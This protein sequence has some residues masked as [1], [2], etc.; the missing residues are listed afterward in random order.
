MLPTLPPTYKIKSDRG[1]VLEGS[2]YE[3]ELQLNKV[4][5]FLIEKI[6]GW[7]NIKKKKHGLVKWVGYDDSYNSWEPEKEIKDLKDLQ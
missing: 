6:L 2:F 1:D 7:K 4:D 5:H 3:A